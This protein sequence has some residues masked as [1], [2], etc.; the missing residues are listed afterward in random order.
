MS[1]AIQRAKLQ[2]Q[3]WKIANDVRGSVDGW[4][5]KQYVLGTLFYRFISENFSS[6]IEAGDDSIKYA[7]LNDD[8]ITDEIK[9]DAI[10]TKG[11]FIYPSQTFTKIAKTAH[12]NES[13]NTD[14]AEIFSAIESSANGY[15]SE[16]DIKGLFA[17]FD[18]TSN[19]LGNTVKDKNSRLAAVIKGVGGLDFGEFEENQ[20][21]L[22]GDAY[23][24]LISN[25]AANAGKSGGEFFTPQS[26]SRL[27]A[28]LA[29]HK[30]TTINK[31]YDPAAGSGSLLLQ[32]KKQFDNHIIE[33]G[34]Y[35]QE[36][37][38]TT[39]NLARMN[40]FLHNINYDKF[41]IGLGNTLLEPHYGDDK[42]F[43]A[44]VSNPPYSVKWIGQDDPTLI[45]DERFAPAGVLAPKSK[46]DF[47]FVLHAL[48]YLSSKGRAAIVCFPGIFYR[49]GAE[50]KIRK[51]LIDNNFIETVISLAPNLFFGTSI[52]VNILVLSKHKSDNKT[53]F[54]D[55]SGIDFYKK[56]TNNNILADEHIAQIIELFD[57]KETI[58]YVAKSVDYDGIVENDY[59]LSVSSYVEA[60]DTREV[61]DIDELNGE[62]KKTVSKI[63]ILRTEI[64]AIIEGIES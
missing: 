32:A 36:I 3:I 2:S 27:I 41:H 24:F 5:F 64:D 18:T 13:L 37:N 33:A 10:K 63:D 31:I 7:E 25:Y 11:Y 30:Q 49:G 55:A 34:F 57:N 20:I 35:G 39:Y 56:E 62:L 48:S 42:P 6:H 28:Q 43:D 23:E 54:I 52:A 17:D 46:A 19:R 22:F 45:N 44:I 4:D 9:E 12:T 15:P 47:A 58:D 51:Y 61:I 38:H 8:I 16:L 60:K 40:M 29:I 26:V 14:L 53:Q 59:N 1:S 21:D 50:Q